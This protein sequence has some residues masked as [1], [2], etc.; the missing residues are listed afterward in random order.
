MEREFEEIYRLYA[1]DL[2]S[3]ENCSV[4]VPFYDPERE[5]MYYNLM[6]TASDKDG[7]GHAVLQARMFYDYN[8]IYQPEVYSVA[9]NGCSAEL[10]SD[11]QHFFG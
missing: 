8:G 2:Y 3:I 6:L 11:L 7:Q 10:I 4:S 9:P 5:K 1:N